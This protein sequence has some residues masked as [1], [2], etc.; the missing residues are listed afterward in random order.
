MWSHS[1]TTRYQRVARHFH[2]ANTGGVSLPRLHDLK[3][4]GIKKVDRAFACCRAYVATVLHH[5]ILS[6]RLNLLDNGSFSYINLQ[7]ALLIASDE[8]RSTSVD[9]NHA[10]E[11]GHQGVFDV[12]DGQS[13]SKHEMDASGSKRENAMIIEQKLQHRPLGLI[14]GLDRSVT[15]KLSAGKR[16][17]VA[18][19][20]IDLRSAMYHRF[21]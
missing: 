6:L 20:K 11:V 9:E 18:L 14:V 21:C 5:G 3:G 15:F 17:D 12:R 2:V 10:I 19:A 1:A 4:N 16:G 8:Q 13:T 7:H